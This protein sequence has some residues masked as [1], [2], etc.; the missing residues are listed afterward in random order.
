MKGESPFLLPEKSVRWRG[1]VSYLGYPPPSMKANGGFRHEVSL[2]QHPQRSLTSSF[3]ACSALLRALCNG[4]W[5][6]GCPETWRF[7]CFCSEEP[8]RDEAGGFFP[9]GGRKGALARSAVL[10]AVLEAAPR[11]GLLSHPLS[12]CKNCWCFK[13]CSNRLYRFCLRF[14]GL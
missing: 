9:Y 7:R 10:C 6:G 13:K 8:Q 4:R 12:F 2:Q 3:L 1:S 14:P 11:A 5:L